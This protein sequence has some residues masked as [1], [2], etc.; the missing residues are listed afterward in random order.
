MV[1]PVGLQLTARDQ[2]VDVT[3]KAGDDD[4]PAAA[5]P[6]DAPISAVG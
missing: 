1:S 5:L 2:L 3:T 4:K 6:V